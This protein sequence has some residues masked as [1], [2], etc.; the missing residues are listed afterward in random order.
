M[1]K[2]I[3]AILLACAL[4]AGSGGAQ[5][6]PDPAW[7]ALAAHPLTSLDGG[8]PAPPP[9]A[10]RPLLLH[11]WASW[12]APCRRELPAL[13]AQ[14]GRWLDA[15]LE[16]RAVSIDREPEKARRFAA[17]LALSLP[18]YH[19]GPAGLARQLDLPALPCSFLFDGEGRLV[20]SVLGDDERGLARLE[21]ALADLLGPAAPA[22]AALGTH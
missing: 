12:C 9:V 8:T 11:F 2:T 19:D 13:D 4:P 3:A 17:E 6:A 10:G 18:L 14:L 1:R 20:V 5:A 16:L 22:A 15:G 21:T 7:Q